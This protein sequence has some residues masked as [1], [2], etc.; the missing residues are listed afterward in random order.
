MPI[1]TTFNYTADLS[2]GANGVL[3]RQPLSTLDANAHAFKVTINRGGELSSDAADLTGARCEGW[4]IR[5]DGVTVPI[6]GET[7]GNVATVTLLP[8]CYAVPG[9]FTLAVKLVQGSVIHTILRAEGSI[10]VSRTDALTEG[11]TGVQSFD[12]I[13]A[14][15]ASVFTAADSAS[16]DAQRAET[17]ADRAEAAADRAEQGGGTGGGSGSP[18][19]DGVSPIVDVSKSGKVT[20]ITITD[21]EG[22]KTATIS[23]GSDGYSP[24]KGTDYWTAEDKAAIVGDVLAILDTSAAAHVVVDD[25][26]NIT[27]S[28]DLADGDY[29]LKYEN[30]DGTFTTI[31]TLTISGGSGE[32]GGTDEPDEPDEPVTP[33]YTNLV[34][35]ALAHTDL[36]TVYNGTG[37]MDGMYASTTPPYTGTDAATVCTGCIPAQGG[38]VYYIKGITMDA[39]INEHCRVILGQNHATSGQVIATIGKPVNQISEYAAIE[40]LG[41]QYYRLTIKADYVS[42]N[43][44]RQAYIWISGIG[45]G[46]NLIVTANEPLA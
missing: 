32:G 11:G 23:D 12:E 1:T 43:I 14:T 4:F 42:A 36:S 45:T 27:L 33:T 44:T 29:T 7:D 37:Y 19:K 9:R 26:K 17:A 30:A 21:A 41:T 3:I 15:M 31:C 46:A 20:T 13:I 38:S 34:P 8:A 22:V 10:D 24:V 25:E 6:D 40:T 39:S 5:A 2:T 35:A 28:G 16:T 18:G